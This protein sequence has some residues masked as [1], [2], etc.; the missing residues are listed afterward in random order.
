MRHSQNDPP[1]LCVSPAAASSWAEATA[2]CSPSLAAP[3][4]RPLGSALTAAASSK[5]PSKMCDG[6]DL[7][8]SSVRRYGTHLTSLCPYLSCSTVPADWLETATEVTKDNSMLVD[9]GDAHQK[10]CAW[11]DGLGVWHASQMNLS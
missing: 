10:V 8:A 9:G 11:V 7:L 1:L 6:M 5:S 2:P 4:A 3:T